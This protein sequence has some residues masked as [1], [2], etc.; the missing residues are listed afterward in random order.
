M[1]GMEIER[2]TGALGVNGTSATAPRTTRGPLQG[3]GLTSPVRLNEAGYVQ[4]RLTFHD[5]VVLT[6]GARLEH[7]GSFGIGLSR[8]PL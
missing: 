7:N 2:E 1:F 4:D 3:L 8:A 5:S 6:A